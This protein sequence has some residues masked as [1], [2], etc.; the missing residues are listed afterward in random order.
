MQF[1]DHSLNLSLAACVEVRRHI[2]MASLRLSMKKN[3]ERT[4]VKFVGAAFVKTEDDESSINAFCL[5]ERSFQRAVYN[6][7]EQYASSEGSLPQILYEFSDGENV[8]DLLSPSFN[9]SEDSVRHR[10]Q[11]QNIFPIRKDYSYRSTSSILCRSLLS[12]G[13]AFNFRKREKNQACN[14]YREDLSRDYNY[15]ECESKELTHS[16][17]QICEDAVNFQRAQQLKRETN[18]KNAKNLSKEME[19]KALE[20]SQGIFARRLKYLRENDP[21][22]HARVLSTQKLS[23]FLI[24]LRK[25]DDFLKDIG[26]RFSDHVMQRSTTTLLDNVGSRF[27]GNEE[28][29]D[30]AELTQYVNNLHRTYKLTHMKEVKLEGKQPSWLSGGQLKPFQITGVE[31]LISLY[32]NNLNGILADLMGLGKTVQTIA[33][34]CHLLCVEKYPGPHIVICPVSLVQQWAD[35]FARWAPKIRVRI[36]GTKDRNGLLSTLS[37]GRSPYPALQFISEVCDTDQLP[38]TTLFRR[39][40]STCLRATLCPNS[41]NANE[42]LFLLCTISFVGFADIVIAARIE[43][44]YGLSTAQFYR[45][46]WGYVVLDEGH[47]AS[48]LDSK[49]TAA[50]RDI[51]CSHKLLLTGTPMKNK[52][53][54][55]WS[56]LNYINPKVFGNISG[57]L[58]SFSDPLQ[59]S[60]LQKSIGVNKDKVIVSQEYWEMTATDLTDEEREILILRL[61]QV[62]RPFMLRR[63]GDDV[64]IKL[65]TKS[66]HYIQCG[67]SALQ[68]KLLELSARGLESYT[69]CTKE[70]AFRRTFRQSS[71]ETLLCSHPAAVE[72]VSDLYDAAIE[73]QRNSL[74]KYLSKQEE[75]LMRSSGKFLALDIILSRMKQLK[76]KTVIFAQRIRIIDLLQ[77]Y[78]TFRGY[79]FVTLHG[80]TA[81]SERRRLVEM[82]QSE[83][84]N[85]FLASM[86]SAAHGIDGLQVSNICIFFD[87]DYTPANDEQ[88]QHR[89][90]RFGQRNHVRVLF[91]VCGVRIEQRRL[92]IA[93][94]KQKNVLLLMKKR[95]AAL[96]EVENIPIRDSERLNSLLALNEHDQ[97]TLKLTSF[98]DLPLIKNW[99]EVCAKTRFI[100][101][102]AVYN[103]EHAANKVLS[104]EYGRGKRLC[105]EYTYEP[106]ISIERLEND[107]DHGYSE[108]AAVE[109]WKRFAAKRRK[110][111]KS[112]VCEFKAPM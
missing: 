57:F 6:S 63:T 110:F 105:V 90:C 40:N 31:W 14:S 104:T 69:D 19:S 71:I 87:V 3:K 64:G 76:R 80:N 103:W 73:Q 99:E 1:S 47:I 51:R 109:R 54:E 8:L 102:R 15:T 22:A 7:L 29:E 38:L 36:M 108:E 106:E 67:I 33:L 43:L 78:F 88:A 100:V 44:T 39:G 68:E 66:T 79:D 91:L 85:V 27:C 75:W 92:N 25:T 77:E 20:L 70:F 28:T 16:Q 50:L 11:L 37:S 89:L 41:K 107:L 59:N 56:L 9:F 58:E 65:P 94:M 86:K 81:R 26:A 72:G 82:F 84:V 55:L 5:E 60:S 101:E 111:K 61:H 46:H 13:H 18:L 112:S 62:I 10:I 12:A 52:V 83:N 34:F 53:R 42:A 96:N 98:Q 95:V 97:N 35:E 23:N 4:P 2:R 32:R 93:D 30:F 49:T 48:N 21:A 74:L 24:I 45:I 17:L